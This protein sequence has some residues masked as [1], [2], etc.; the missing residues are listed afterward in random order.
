MLM[1]QAEWRESKAEEYPEDER[2][3]SC[4]RALHSLAAFVAEGE[5]ATQLDCIDEA[6][7]WEGDPGWAAFSLPE[8][9]K[10]CIA[11]YGFDPP[12]GDK[13]PEDHLAFL[14][15]LSD[16]MLAW[17]QAELADLASLK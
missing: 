14:D 7:P 6:I 1:H 8:P 9:A 2:N 11:R 3:L 16:E 10:E 12:R 17:A 4:A 13:T 5:G 15:E